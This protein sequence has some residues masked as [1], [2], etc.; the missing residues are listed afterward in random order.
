MKSHPPKKVVT[1]KIFLS[2]FKWNNPSIEYEMF[3]ER[4]KV[5][6]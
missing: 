4:V 3:M 6:Q 1:N 2:L 5:G